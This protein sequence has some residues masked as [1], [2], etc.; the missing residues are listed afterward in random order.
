[1]H[2]VLIWIAF[3][4]S[5][6]NA[7]SLAPDT[8]PGPGFGENIYGFRLENVVLGR[9]HGND[10]PYFETLSVVVELH[11]PPGVSF[12]DYLEIIEVTRNVKSTISLANMTGM[13]YERIIEFVAQKVI[14][15]YPVLDS[16]LITAYTYP[17]VNVTFERICE[18]N[19]RRNPIPNTSF[20]TSSSGEAVSIAVL[21]IG[22]IFWT[23]TVAIV[24][25]VLATLCKAIKQRG[26]KYQPLFHDSKN[27]VHLPLTSSNE[28]PEI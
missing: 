3:I 7:Q 5:L 19:L 18:V 25:A 12:T 16:V 23:A 1:M 24:S 9:V 27:P 14:D 22:I 4:I 26:E 11:Y 6:S 21:V 2:S 17:N 28:L 13:Y 20:V 15:T 10:K 8:N